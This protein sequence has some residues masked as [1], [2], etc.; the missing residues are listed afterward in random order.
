MQT[1]HF[2]QKKSF[3]ILSFF[4][5]FFIIVSNSSCNNGEKKD[6]KIAAVPENCFTITR[7][8]IKTNMV[9]GHWSVPA[10]NDFIPYFYFYPSVDA[11]TGAIQIIAY[12]ADKDNR[13]Y[14][15]RKVNMSPP[16]MTPPCSFPNDLI[17]DT[18]RYDFSTEGFADSDGRLIAFDFLRL[19]PRASTEPGYETYMVFDVYMITSNSDGTETEVYKSYTKPCPPYCPVQ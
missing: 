3:I 13:L 8:E 11:G 7:D 17:V 12:P 9:A 4:A 16:T 6:I 10:D 15:A 2:F 1:N 19:I 14:Q 5:F 18:S